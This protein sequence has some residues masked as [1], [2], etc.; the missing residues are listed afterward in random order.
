[1]TIRIDKPAET[2][3]IDETVELF[4]LN[5]V[6]YHVPNRTRPNVSL[7]YLRLAQQKGEGVAAA[8]LI[9]ALVGAEG[10]D[11]LSEYEHLTD[12]QYK[13]VMKAARQ[14][15]LGSVVPDKS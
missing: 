9:E 15:V 10:F 12:E 3:D 13:S 1:M 11:A 2:P 6:K 4:E 8:Y 7:K 14:I 5:G